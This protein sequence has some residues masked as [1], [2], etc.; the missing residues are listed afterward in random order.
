MKTRS[1]RISE[2]DIKRLQELNV[3]L[4]DLV[5]DTIKEV[6]KDKRC[7]TCGAPIKRKQRYET[8]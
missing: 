5:R 1:I 7:P 6:I 3:D 8:K 4:S 2:D